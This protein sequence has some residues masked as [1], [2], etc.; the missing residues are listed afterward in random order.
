VPECEYKRLSKSRRARHG[1][2]GPRLRQRRLVCDVAR[3]SGTG[4][5]EGIGTD[6][7]T[8]KDGAG[9]H[10]ATLAPWA[11]KGNGH[12]LPE[13]Q[14]AGGSTTTRVSYRQLRFDSARADAWVGDSRE[15]GQGHDNAPSDSTSIGGTSRGRATEPTG[16]HDPGTPRGRSRETAEER[17]SHR[18]LRA[19]PVGEERTGGDQP[20]P[21]TDGGTRTLSRGSGRSVEAISVRT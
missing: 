17:R 18:G 3:R 8:K 19:R 16:G 14:S 21:N 7:L 5:K 11:G 15:I 6:E 2:P 4:A 13:H 1:R 12:R 9:G 10:R 20:T